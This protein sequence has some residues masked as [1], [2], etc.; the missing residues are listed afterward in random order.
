MRA[1][2]F[3][4]SKWHDISLQRLLYTYSND[5]VLFFCCYYHN[6]NRSV[7]RKMK[8]LKLKFIINVM[9]NVML[10]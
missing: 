3:H 7:S 6:R 2:V 1:R 9:K 10:L 5:D 8:R 4:S